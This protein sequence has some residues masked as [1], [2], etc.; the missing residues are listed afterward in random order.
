MNI[1]SLLHNKAHYTRFIL[2]LLVLFLLTTVPVQAARLFCRSDPVV[3]L[4]DGAIFD[5]SADISTL[6]FAVREVHY[7]L[8]GP[9]GTS[10]VAVIHTPTWLTSQETFEYIADQEPGVYSATVLVHTRLGNAPVTA[11]AVVTTLAGIRLDF[12]AVRG[13]E[14]VP[15][16]VYMR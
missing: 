3:I 10:T 1:L 11:N 2:I 5:I 6:P 4:S 7:T 8:H 16:H 12:Y 14:G 9:V 13:V 15:I